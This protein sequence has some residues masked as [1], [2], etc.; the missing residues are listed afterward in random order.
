MK[1]TSNLP[2]SGDCLPSS[3]LHFRS[4][5]A[6]HTL[7]LGVTQALYV[8]MQRHVRFV[9]RVELSRS[10]LAPLGGSIGGG[11][12]HSH[13]NHQHDAH[14]STT[15][16]TTT[17]DHSQGHSHRSSSG[18]T[19]KSSNHGSH[20]RSSSSSRGSRGSRV[21]RSGTRRMGDGLDAGYL[22][23]SDPWQFLSQLVR[24][25]IRHPFELLGDCGRGMP[26]GKDMYSDTFPC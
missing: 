14:E 21:H 12:N 24:V 4:M 8:A 5:V 23:A 1:C 22:S 6:T 9:R 26:F 15:Q 7:T 18:S 11:L 20:G 13:H 19:G 25:C 17:G 10:V 3:T 2:F 16:P